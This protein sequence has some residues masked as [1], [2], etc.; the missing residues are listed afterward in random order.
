[1]ITPAEYR[2]RVEYNTKIAQSYYEKEGAT[3]LI[4][5]LPYLYAFD[6]K[7]SELHI[8]FLI[9]NAYDIIPSVLLGYLP[10][11]TNHGADGIALVGN[12][13]VELEYKWATTNTENN[14]TT[15]LRK[16]VIYRGLANTKTRR[17]CFRSSIQGAFQVHS[18]AC[19]ESKRR[20]TILLVSDSSVPDCIFVDA[21]EL[22]GDTTHKYISGTNC[23]GRERTTK[24]RN[25][26]VATFLNQGR[27]VKHRSFLD[28]GIRFEDYENLL[29]ENLPSYDEWENGERYYP[30]YDDML[31]KDKY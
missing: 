27:S 3:G 4:S 12:K 20:R 25:I 31:E 16:K 22:D 15:D 5:M 2:K 1:M 23:Y 17:Q 14:W 18:D 30:T 7:T 13:F 21:F 6:G 29:L 19:I 8:A 24:F 10:C 28:D 26:K 9:K 11:V